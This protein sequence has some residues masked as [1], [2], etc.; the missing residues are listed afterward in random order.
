M[1]FQ[2][3]SPSS[4]RPV[5]TTTATAATW[6]GLAAVLALT[7][8]ATPDT[9]PH[10]MDHES[11]RYFALELDSPNAPLPPGTERVG[12]VG[13][14]SEHHVLVRVPRPHLD[15]RGLSDGGDHVAAL[16]GHV[17]VRSVEVQ[18]PV[19]RLFKRAPVVIAD[20]LLPPPMPVSSDPTTSARLSDAQALPPPPPA[21]PT[22]MPLQAAQEA[23]VRLGVRDPGF[24]RQWHLVL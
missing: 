14:L 1:R 6:L 23:A 17:G 22:S 19:Q 5:G 18:V 3:S 20:P 4:S 7:V 9:K 11:Y 24:P 10:R 12:A 16:K 15:G 21:F 8:T 2:S 13:A